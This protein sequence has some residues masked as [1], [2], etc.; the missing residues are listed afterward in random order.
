METQCF[1][2]LDLNN[3]KHLL[4]FVS[5]AHMYTIVINSYYL[6]DSPTAKG[7]P[8][9]KIFHV[10]SAKLYTAESRSHRSNWRSRHCI[11]SGKRTRQ[12]NR[13]K[14]IRSVQSFSKSPSKFTNTIMVLILSRYLVSRSIDGR[15]LSVSEKTTWSPREGIQHHTVKILL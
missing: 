5:S 10:S 11:F 2:P 14:G 1:G 12:D 15:Q 6:L 4:E 3:Y 13:E 9:S 8:Q 7:L